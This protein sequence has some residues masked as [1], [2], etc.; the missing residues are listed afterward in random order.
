MNIA[1]IYTRVS[2]REQQQEGFSLGAQSKLLREYALRNRFD[3]VMSFEDVETAKSS[4]R[5]QFGEMVKWLKRNR[6]CR[7]LIVEKT[8]RLYRNFRDAVDLE[9][10]EIAIHFVKENQVISKEAK[11]Q[12]KFIHGIN[13]VV[14]K[15]YSDNL[16]EEVSKGM[17]EKASEGG[18]PGHAPFGYRNNKG[19]RSIEIDPVDSIMVD[20]MMELYATGAHTISSLRKM[21]KSDF[22]KTMSRGNINLILKNK[23]YIGWFN[24]S[25]ETWRGTHPLFVNPKTFARVQEVL[26]GHNRPKYSKREIAFRGLMICA[27]DDCMLTGDVQKKKYVYYRC[28]G[29]RGKC[30]LPRFREEDIALR[31]GEPLKGLQVP[32]DVVS[33]IVTALRDDEE[34]SV[35]KVDAEHSRLQGRLTNIRNRM[36]QAYTD[37]LDG[38]ISEEFWRRKTN[39]WRLEEEQVKMALNALASAQTGDRAMDA[40]KIFEL[41]N[42]AY[43]LYVSQDSVEQAKLLKMFVSNFSVG[44][45]SVTPAYRYPFNLIFQR[46]KMEE[47][48]GRLDSN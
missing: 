18:F 45:V 16:R 12:A 4:G 30:E 38:V 27:N 43:L 36:D 39:E 35:G 37:K 34:E 22:G 46:A 48:S 28:T 47:W 10:L 31:L 8:D 21:L 13:L 5:K 23:F 41:A 17:R 29:Y 14:A 15:N 7:I 26:A 25:G 1:I 42:K 6:S 11:S 2:S 19:E 33:R 9:E 40:E 44:N 3:I 20:R 32:A 24:W